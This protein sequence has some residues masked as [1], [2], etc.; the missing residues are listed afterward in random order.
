[1]V[2][3]SGWSNDSSKKTVVPQDVTED[4]NGN[5]PRLEVGS[6]AQSVPSSLHKRHRAAAAAQLHVAA[7][8][9]HDMFWLTYEAEYLREPTSQEL[10]LKKSP[11]YYVI[12]YKNARSSSDSLPAIGDETVVRSVVLRYE[13]ISRHLI[14]F[15]A[16]TLVSHK[17]QTRNENPP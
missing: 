8:N 9:N 2:C 12:I 13:A 7:R 15:N 6:T 14:L 17:P 5:M 16:C 3:V 10:D 11:L 4:P 1:M